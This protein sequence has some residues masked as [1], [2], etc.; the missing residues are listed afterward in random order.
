MLAAV[1]SPPLFSEPSGFEERSIFPRDW[2]FASE[3]VAEET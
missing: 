1:P 3:I 2:E